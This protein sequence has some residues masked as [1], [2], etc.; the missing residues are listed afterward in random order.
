MPLRLHGPDRRSNLPGWEGVDEFVSAGLKQD[1][2]I[3][4]I[5][6]RAGGTRNV[7]AK[8]REFYRTWSVT[9]G[10]DDSVILYAA[11]LAAGKTFS[12]PFMNQLLS[13]W[14]NAGITTVDGAKK[15]SSPKQ[16]P[17]TYTERI[18]Y[19]AV[20]CAYV[21]RNGIAFF[22]TLKVKGFKAY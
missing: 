5:I 2:K 17:E 1:G 18:D 14:K 8:D 13:G 11:E 9:W 10:F 4:E 7:T 6:E 15:A 16:H 19:L 22:I 21:N 20:F 3:K 12:M